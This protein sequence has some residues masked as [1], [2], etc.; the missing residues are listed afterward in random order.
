MHGL[1][2]DGYTRFNAEYGIYAI[3][4]FIECEIKPGDKV[5]VANAQYVMPLVRG[6]FEIL[7]DFEAELI[8]FC[9][10][11]NVL[12]T[13]NTFRCGLAARFNSLP[14]A[15]YAITS[16]YNYRWIK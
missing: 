8:G 9:Y 7:E 14:M 1:F 15:E 10:Q 5:I 6:C 13:L 12:F 2:N 4:R 16:P 11:Y 3:L